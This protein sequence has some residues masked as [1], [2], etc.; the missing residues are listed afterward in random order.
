MTSSIDKAAAR[1]ATE[2]GKAIAKAINR[3]AAYLEDD[4]RTVDADA[5]RAVLGRQAGHYRVAATDGRV[6]LL[7]HGT[8]TTPGGNV[9]ILVDALV[10]PSMATPAALRPALRRVL[11]CAPRKSAA[12]YPGCIRLRTERER[13]ILET[14]DPTEGCSATEWMPADGGDLAGRNVAISGHFLLEALAIAGDG[15]ISIA[16]KRTAKHQIDGDPHT[17]EGGPLAFTAA[18]GA[19]AVV[20]MGMYLPRE[21]K[22]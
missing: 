22:A 20:V 17:Y 7:E 5:A 14:S 21:A 13:V 1:A 4:A 8:A 10:G 3:M 6:A 9:P 16:H 2:R 18:D 19:W 12:S 15:R 11:T